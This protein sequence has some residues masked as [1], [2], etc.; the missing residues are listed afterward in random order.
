MIKRLAL[1]EMPHAV[2]C[3][4]ALVCGKG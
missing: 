1:P 3:G 2:E 4:F